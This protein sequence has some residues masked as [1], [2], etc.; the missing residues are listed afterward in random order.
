MTLLLE[1]FGGFTLK[2][3]VCFQRNPIAKL[4]WYTSTLFCN[5]AMVAMATMQVVLKPILNILG[6]TSR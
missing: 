2:S 6:K 4:A 1:H 3:D 5:D